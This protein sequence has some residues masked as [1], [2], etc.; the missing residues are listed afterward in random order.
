MASNIQNWRIPNDPDHDKQLADIKPVSR[1]AASLLARR[2]QS[3]VLRRS[4]V[5][6]Y[7]A[8]EI[9]KGLDYHHGN[10]MRLLGQ[11]AQLPAFSVEEADA[12]DCLLHELV[13]YVSRVGQFLVFAKSRFVNETIRDTTA[14][15]PT[16]AGLK[17]FRDKV[18]AHRSI[19]DPRTEDTPELQV[20]HARVLTP[21]IGRLFEPKPGESL[22]D[23][24]LG[25]E[26]PWLKGYLTYYL[27]M[28]TPDADKLALE[29]DHPRIMEEAYSVLERLLAS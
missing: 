22:E 23:V 6:V 14:L 24:A 8:V 16:L 19:D 4:F 11:L 5:N 3:P 17:R 10:F 28:G 15:I 18:A 27:P 1:R 12:F 2:S 29:R 26:R 9:M 13:A 20:V 25:R 7:G 21:L